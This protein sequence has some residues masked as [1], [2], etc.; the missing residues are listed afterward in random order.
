MRIYNLIRAVTEPFPGAF[1]YLP[2]GEKLFIWW[3]LPETNSVSMGPVGA[4]GFE[5]DHVYARA[6]D[7]RLRLLDIGVRKQR[8]KDHQIHDFFKNQQGV[9][10]K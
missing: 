1:T 5:K 2:G 8:M 9:V 7:G 6:S 10:L 4:L 3:G